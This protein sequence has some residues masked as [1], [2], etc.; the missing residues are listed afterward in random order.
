MMANVALGDFP[1]INDIVGVLTWITTRQRAQPSE[2]E[3]HRS[4]LGFTASLSQKIPSVQNA[5]G[6]AKKTNADGF[7]ERW[8]ACLV[9]TADCGNLD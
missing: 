4:T 1:P 3:T 5:T 8:Y 6:A 2:A 7:Y 9:R